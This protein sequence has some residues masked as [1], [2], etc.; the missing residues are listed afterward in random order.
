MVWRL[1]PILR[2]TQNEV[3]HI[4]K[5]KRD[6]SVGLRVPGFPHPPARL[7]ERAGLAAVATDQE[8]RE[9]QKTV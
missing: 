8:D 3:A 2:G 9:A 7:T 5:A 6:L 1:N 4:L